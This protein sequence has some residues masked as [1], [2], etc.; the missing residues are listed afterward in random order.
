MNKAERLARASR[1]V[2]PR[3][4]EPT[5]QGFKC[6]PAG[7]PRQRRHRWD[8]EGVCKRCGNKRN[9]PAMRLTKY[10]K[11]HGISVVHAMFELDGA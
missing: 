3:F 9:G 10:A 4:V 11:E 7:R 8:A 1:V 2:Q 6:R 5:Y